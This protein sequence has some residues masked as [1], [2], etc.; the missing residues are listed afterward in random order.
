MEPYHE[1]TGSIGSFISQGRVRP[2]T[3]CIIAKK[4]TYTDAAAA[5]D[6][7]APVKESFSEMA[8]KNTTIL[9]IVLAIL[10]L[11]LVGAVVYLLLRHKNGSERTTTESPVAADPAPTAQIPNYGGIPV[12]TAD[13]SFVNPGVRISRV[14]HIGKRANQEDSLG[15]SNVNDTALYAAKGILAVVADGM[16]GLKGGEEVSSRVVLSMLRG[17]SD[18]ATGLT[19]SDE[20]KRLLQLAVNE[21]NDYLTRTI[22]LKKG[23][24]T[25][26]ALIYKDREISWISVGDSRIALF[27]GGKLTDLNIKHNYGTELDE[28]VR[29]NKITVQQAQSNPHRNE[30]TSYIGMGVLKYVDGSVRPMPSLPGDKIILMTDGIF[31]ALSDPEIEQILSLPTEQ[32]GDVF[33]RAVLQKNAAYQDNFTAVVLELP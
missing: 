19:S 14:H 2:T 20:L 13:G 32:T 5:T 6:V 24:S 15:V 8:Q 29:Q 18:A 21:A 22:G 25:L 3:A 27:R 12:T 26:V 33:E 16:G 10:V 11:I 7:L 17:F 28:M 1:M 9:I 4:S 31:N 30:L 23:G